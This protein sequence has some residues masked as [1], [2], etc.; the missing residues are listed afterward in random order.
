MTT[1]LTRFCEG[2]IEA[3]WLAAIIVL[4]LFF[5]VFSS[6]VFEPD[7]ITLLRSLSLLILA[8]WLIKT[9]DQIAA[10]GNARPIKVERSELE[11]HSANIVKDALGFTSAVSKFCSTLVSTIFS[12]T[13]APACGDP[14]NASRAHTRHFPI[15]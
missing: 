10:R 6:R 13:P 2:I 1:K 7:K 8:V 4:P 9:L 5:N 11:A 15:W 12:V 14:T 3:A